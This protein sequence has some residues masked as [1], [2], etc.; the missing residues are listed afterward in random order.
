MA[1]CAEARAD[2]MKK[3]RDSHAA[4]SVRRLEIPVPAD[5]RSPEA[6]L[7]S[8]LGSRSAARRAILALQEELRLPPDAPASVSAALALTRLGADLGLV[9]RSLKWDEFEQYCAMAISA[10]GFTVRRNVRLRK[11]TRQ[12]DIVADSPTLVLSVDCKH[13]KRSAG[14]GG[15]IAPALAQVE[16]TKIYALGLDQVKGRALLPMLLTM[17]DNQVRLA[18]GVPIVPLQALREFLATVSRFDESLSFVRV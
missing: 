5:A 11:P 2:S 10:A 1:A 16:R 6:M 13:W 18:E 12:I 4:R 8:K 14:E 17:V 15:L 9:A 7:A 3:R